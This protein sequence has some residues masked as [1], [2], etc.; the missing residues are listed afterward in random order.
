MAGRPGWWRG[1]AYR[2]VHPLRRVRK[3]CNGCH[4]RGYLGRCCRSAASARWQRRVVRRGAQCAQEGERAT[5]RRGPARPAVG[6]LGAG[7][8]RARALHAVRAQPG[9]GLLRRAARHR[10]GEAVSAQGAGDP[11]RQPRQPHGHAGDPVGAAAQ[12]A[13]A[14]R[15][16]RGGRLLLPQPAGRLA[17][18]AHLQHGPDR[19]QGRRRPVQGRQPPRPAARPGLEPAALPRGHPLARRRPRPGAPRRRGPGRGAQPVD[20]PD[21]RHRH[22]RGD[23][24]R[25]AVAPAP[26]R[27]AALQ[28]PPDHRLLRR[29]DPAQR[30]HRR[31]DRAGAELLRQR[32]RRSVAVALPPVGSRPRRSPDRLPA[33][34]RRRLRLRP[35]SG[36]MR[37]GPVRAGARANVNGRAGEGGGS[38]V[39]GERGFASRRR[40]SA[41]GAY[42]C[43]RG[44]LGGV[45]RSGHSLQQAIS[46]TPPRHGR[47]RGDTSHR[48]QSRLAQPHRHSHPSQAHAFE[49]ALVPQPYGTPPTSARRR[50][51]GAT[52]QSY[53]SSS[54]SQSV[55]RA[56][57][58]RHLR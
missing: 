25:P 3:V 17:R 9:D 23:A 49:P 2:P 22:R 50:H 52:Q 39:G 16:G 26:A 41:D 15:G 11:G 35:W 37:R 8:V 55:V 1:R 14:H 53:S 40:R 28:A 13:Q 34:L 56:T 42:T 19:A 43:R 6:A 31:A 44:R 20:H 45:A 36:A 32:R 47:S 48:P 29:A 10:P 58:L 27:Q 12:A 24:P 33:R 46:P 54:S 7:P 18:V 38:G 57:A 21:P 30:R 5:R 4:A 51:T